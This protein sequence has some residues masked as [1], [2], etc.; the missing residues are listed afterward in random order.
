MGSTV[1]AEFTLH[2]VYLDAYYIDKHEVSNAHYYQCEADGACS[3][4][5]SN[6]SATRPSYYG[7]PIFANYPVIGVN[8]Y[9]ASNYCTWAGK[10]LPT[11]AEWEKAARGDL[12]VRRFPWGDDALSCTLLNYDNS[13]SLDVSCV[14]DTTPVTSYPLGASPYNVLN[15]LGNTSEWVND[16]YNVAYYSIS[17]YENPPGPITGTLKIARGCSFGCVDY[18]IAIGMRGQ[19]ADPNWGLGFRC[20]DSP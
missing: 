20:A 10:R 17:P 6:S 9:N 15:M 8:W 2:A 7:N 5:E 16:W 11:E 18:K 14:G 4:P 19:G 12:D 3:P 1:Y 13:Y